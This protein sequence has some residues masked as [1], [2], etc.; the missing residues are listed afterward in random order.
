MVERLN[1]DNSEHSMHSVKSG[2]QTT[3]DII[4]EAIVETFSSCKRCSF[5]TT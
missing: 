1:G 3:K 5:N 4:T 2:S